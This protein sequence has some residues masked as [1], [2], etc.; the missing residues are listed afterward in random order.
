MALVEEANWFGVKAAERMMKERGH[1][2][3]S[4]L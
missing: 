1:S 3:T 2:V 4:W